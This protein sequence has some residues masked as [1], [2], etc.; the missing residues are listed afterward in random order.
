MIE[1]DGKKKAEYRSSLRSK[2]LIKR[3]LLEM[4]Q[5]KVFEKISVSDIVRKADINRGTFYAHFKDPQDVMMRIQAD[6][7][8][9]LTL[10]LNNRTPEEMLMDPEPSLREISEFLIKDIPYYRMLL[11]VSNVTDYLKQNKDRIIKYFLDST[12]AKAI[13]KN[14]KTKEFVI[15]LDFWISGIF[16]IFYDV[17]MENIPLRMDE[18]PAI[19]AVILK[20]S[21]RGASELEGYVPLDDAAAKTEE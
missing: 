3:A 12:I 16:N 5:E 15:L 11:N 20:M 14:G 9:E 8:D 4:M 17:V 2:A 18:V 6:M 7:F 13:E 1:T 10:V 21:S 19:C